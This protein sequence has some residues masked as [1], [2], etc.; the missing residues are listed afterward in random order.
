MFKLKIEIFL[1]EQNQFVRC[2]LNAWDL[3]PE[4]DRDF[5]FLYT[6]NE[7]ELYGLVD[8][9]S[10]ESPTWRNYATNFKFFMD[11]LYTYDNVRNFFKL[12]FFEAK[13]IFFFLL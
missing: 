13:K 9:L 10:N 8:D 5:Y 12:N 3:Q 6:G 7:V 1:E 4:T 2:T 11:E